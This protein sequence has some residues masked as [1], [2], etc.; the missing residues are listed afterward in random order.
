MSDDNDTTPPAEDA[1]AAGPRL[2]RAKMLPVEDVVYCLFHSAVHEDTLDPYNSG[3]DECEKD[4][5]RPVYYRARKGDYDEVT[6]AR[7]VAG[8]PQ[9]GT[10]EAVGEVGEGSVIV[11][12]LSA[13]QEQVMRRVIAAASVPLSGDERRLV[14][15]LLKREYDRSEAA[16]GEL[17][18]LV[19][20]GDLSSV[21]TTLNL[22]HSALGKIGAD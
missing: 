14:S 17:R 1:P 22:L 18:E 20:H 19:G 10:S 12:N 8:E 5:H 7:F 3:Q 13:V 2:T 4:E 21:E 9:H 16:Y 11:D 6:E 15:R